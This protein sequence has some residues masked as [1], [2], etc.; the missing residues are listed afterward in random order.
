[1]AETEA[2]ASSKALI[3]GDGGSVAMS[4][5]LGLSPEDFESGVDGDFGPLWSLAGEI[6]PVGF[7][8]GLWFFPVGRGGPERD[9]GVGF[10]RRERRRRWDAK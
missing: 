4:D 10:R 2:C 5:D 6:H 3:L 9:T 1:M 8:F 7:F